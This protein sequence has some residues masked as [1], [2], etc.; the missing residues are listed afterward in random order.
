MVAPQHFIT[1][2]I[3]CARHFHSVNLTTRRGTEQD[4]QWE[5]RVRAPLPKCHTG[6]LFTLQMLSFVVTLWE[7]RLAIVLSLTFSLAPEVSLEKRR[8]WIYSLVQA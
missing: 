3:H 8:Q 4:R 7:E 2:D 1:F 5:K 6:W